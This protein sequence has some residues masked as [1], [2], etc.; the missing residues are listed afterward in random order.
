[1]VNTRTTIL[2][3]KIFP[4]CPK[5]VALY[6]PGNKYRFVLVKQLVFVIWMIC[7]LYEVRTELLYDFKYSVG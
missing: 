3:I 7:V 5:S 1:M 2:I 4:F 6:N